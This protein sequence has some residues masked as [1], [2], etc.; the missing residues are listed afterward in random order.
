MNTGEVSLYTI[1]SL[2]IGL[3]SG[4]TKP[5]KHHDLLVIYLNCPGPIMPPLT[6]P[7]LA[8]PNISNRCLEEGGGPCGPGAPPKGPCAAWPSPINASALGGIGGKPEGGGPFMYPGGGIIPGGGPNPAAPLP[9]A[10]RGKPRSFR[11]GMF[12]CIGIAFA[13]KLGLIPRFGV[14]IPGGGA[15]GL[16]PPPCCGGS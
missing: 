8:W 15:K 13:M 9:P 11:G 2:H 14:G 16:G 5:S 4:T 12:P 7:P 3:G 10:A 6:S 1:C